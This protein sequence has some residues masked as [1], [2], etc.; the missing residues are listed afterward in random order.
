M[1]HEVIGQLTVSVLLKK[2]SGFQIVW[3]PS[4]ETDSGE[5]PAV[6]VTTL[7]HAPVSESVL[8]QISPD[9]VICHESRSCVFDPFVHR[10][11]TCVVHPA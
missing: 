3:A 6:Y 7:S 8:E 2:V 11:Q 1:V 5:A 4:G 10:I 9:Y